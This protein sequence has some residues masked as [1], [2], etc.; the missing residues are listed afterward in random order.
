VLN[1]GQC[2]HACEPGQFCRD[3]T[4]RVSCGEGLLVCEGTCHDPSFDPNHCGGCG[5]SCDENHGGF[6]EDGTCSCGGLQV[7]CGGACVDLRTDPENCGACGQACGMRQTCNNGVCTTLPD[8]LVYAVSPSPLPFVNAC[9]KPGRLS[10]L[11]NIDDAAAPVMLPFPF[12]FFGNSR[13]SAWVSTNGL[14]GFGASTIEFDNEC[15]FNELGHATRNTVLAFWDDLQTRAS[16]VCV[17]TIGTA[18]NRQFVATWNDA[19]LLEFLGT[20]HLTFSVVLSE[21]TEVID[22][23][24]DTVAGP[25]TVAAGSSASIGLSNDTRYILECCNEPCIA[26]GTGRRYTPIIR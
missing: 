26:S 6:C 8:G 3:G 17:A 12:R 22:V 23:L 14:F 19:A 11:A 4:C 21:T 10:F 20:S 15:S 13:A 1:C 24:Y 16:G 2:G 7:T 9:Q 18:P 5:I 25:G